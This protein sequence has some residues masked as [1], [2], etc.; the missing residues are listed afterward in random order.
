[1]AR[2][3]DGI[4]RSGGTRVATMRLDQPA[5][6]CAIGQNSS[7]AGL[8]LRPDMR[9]LPTTPTTV[10]ALVRPRFLTTIC[11][12]TAFR[13]GHQRAAAVSLTIA[14]GDEPATSVAPKRRPA[15]N[16]MPIT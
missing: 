9:E 10:Y 2:R 11:C 14:T 7:A 12:P 15:F 16:G 8:R 1:M 3:S 6:L 4:T 13:P 5:S